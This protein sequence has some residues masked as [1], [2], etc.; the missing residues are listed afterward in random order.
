VAPPLDTGHI[1]S[2]AALKF[3]FEFLGMVK[4]GAS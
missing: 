3:I 1:T 4:I 2:L